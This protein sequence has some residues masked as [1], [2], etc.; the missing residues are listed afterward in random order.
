MGG[1]ILMRKGEPLSLLNSNAAAA[2]VIPKTL[3][4]TIEIPPQFQIPSFRQ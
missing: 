4:L 3:S 2:D 1:C